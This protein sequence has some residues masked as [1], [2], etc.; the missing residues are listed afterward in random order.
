MRFWIWL[1]LN[2]IGSAYQLWNRGFDVFLG[3]SRGNPYSRRHKTLS[4][5]QG[6][7]WH[8]SFQVKQN[9]LKRV[10]WNFIGLNFEGVGEIRF[11]GSRTENGESSGQRENLVHRTQS[12]LASRIRRSNRRPVLCSGF[13]KYES[14]VWVPITCIANGMWHTVCLGALEMRQNGKLTFTTHTVFD[15]CCIRC[16]PSVLPLL[17]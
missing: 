9:C 15:V 17:S 12:R 2:R 8:W 10:M 16:I 1:L 4:P 7:F 5:K 14:L 11:S 6:D 13:N 3:N